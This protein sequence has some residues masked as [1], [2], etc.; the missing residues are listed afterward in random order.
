M[1]CRILCAILVY[2]RRQMLLLIPPIDLPEVNRQPAAEMRH[3]Q[4]LAS[5]SYVKVY[6]RGL[7]WS[8]KEWSCLD[9]LVY[10]ESRWDM[11]ANN[12]KSSAY[13]LFQVLKTPEDSTLYDQVQ[14]GLR[15]IDSRYDG[16][17]CKALRHHNRKNWY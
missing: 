9:E 11:S 5:R 12:P 7:G 16:S 6:V 10:R 4:P 13:G 14:A 1:V 8:D 2:V 15:Y 17:S 3:W